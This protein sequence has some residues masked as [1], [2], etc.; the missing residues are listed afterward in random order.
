MTYAQATPPY[1]SDIPGKVQTAMV[2]AYKEDNTDPLFPPGDGQE[3]IDCGAELA[4]ENC[5]SSRSLYTPKRK[6][7]F[8]DDQIFDFSESTKYPKD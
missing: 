8:A 1:D 4:G 2:N 3:G 5:P 6:L 7:N